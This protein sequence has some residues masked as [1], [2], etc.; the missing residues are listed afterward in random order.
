MGLSRILHLSQHR[1]ALFDCSVNDHFVFSVFLKYIYIYIYIYIY[2]FTSHNNVQALLSFLH[3]CCTVVTSLFN[4]LETRFFG[5][6]ET[7]RSMV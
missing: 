1:P 4:V 7:V 5:E 3:P 6:T 2:V